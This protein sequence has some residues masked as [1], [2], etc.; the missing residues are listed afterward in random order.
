MPWDEVPDKWKAG[1][2]HSGG[3]GGPKVRSQKQMVAIMLAEKRKAQGGD[4]EYASKSDAPI[5]GL[6]KAV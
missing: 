3:P 6:K 5:R 4:S 2:L 1:T